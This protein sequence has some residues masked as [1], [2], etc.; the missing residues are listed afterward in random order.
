[1]NNRRELTIANFVLLYQY[2]IT[3]F[4]YKPIDNEQ[5]P[6]VLIILL[7]ILFYIGHKVMK[8]SQALFIPNLILALLTPAIVFNYFELENVTLL[9]LFY[10]ITWMVL[11]YIQHP[12]YK[13]T[14]RLTG[15]ALSFPTALILSF[16]MTWES[17]LYAKLPFYDAAPD[18]KTLIVSVI[19]SILYVVYALTLVNKNSLYGVAIVCIFILRFY[20]D[21]SL[22]FMDKSIAFIVGGILLLALGL[23]FEKTR[24]KEVDKD[25]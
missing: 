14:M 10:F 12:D 17:M 15:Y 22:G 8:K 11:T 3:Q 19:F 16:P 25:E 13:Y 23:W 18:N 20:V 9:I 21:L 4:I 6:F 24:R 2:T 7:P 5:F 1:M